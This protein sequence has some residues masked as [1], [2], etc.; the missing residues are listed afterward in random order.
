ML[1]MQSTESDGLSDLQ[2]RRETPII[3]MAGREEQTDKGPGIRIVA[4]M[5]SINQS[6]FGCFVMLEFSFY[7]SLTRVV[8]WQ[9][10]NA[11]QPG[12]SSGE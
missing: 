9:N 1:Q 5:D 4:L 3:G 2:D 10:S 6:A 8:L 7:P 12:P 11:I